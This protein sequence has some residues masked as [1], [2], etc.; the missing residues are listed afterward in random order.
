MKNGILLDFERMEARTLLATFMV[1]NNSP[2][3]ATSGSLAYEITQSN[4]TPATASTPNIIQ[5]DIAASGQQTI[6]LTQELP[7]VT[8]PL[9][10]QGYSEPGSSANTNPLTMADNAVL[11]VIVTGG[12]S[13]EN[14]LIFDIAAAG[15]SVEG[16]DLEGFTNN[17]ITINANAVA[18]SGT[19]IGVAPNGVPTA[20]TTNTVGVYVAGAGGGTIGGTAAANRN[21]ITGETYEAV[22]YM[23]AGVVYPS[24]NTIEGNFIGTDSDGTTIPSNTAVRNGNGVIEYAGIGNT[25][26]GSATG[27]G[28]V[29]SGNMIYGVGIATS[30]GVVLAGDVIQSNG[31]LGVLLISTSGTSITASTIG[32]T[33]A[34]Q[35]N[36]GQGIFLVGSTGATIGGTLAGAGDLIAGNTGDGIDFDATATGGLVTGSTISGNSGAGLS[37]VGTSV[38]LLS[39]EVVSSD[40]IQTNQVDGLDISFAPGTVVT[41]STIGGTASGQGNGG[42]GIRL[43][44]SSNVTIGGTALGVLVAGNLGDGIDFDTSSPNGQVLGTT[45]TGNAGVGVAF[46]GDTATNLTGSLLKLD[47]ITSNARGGVIAD[48]ASGTTLMSST[49]GG[50]EGLGNGAFGVSLTGSAGVT[51]A[52]STVIGNSGD[53]VDV[54]GSPGLD[55]TGGVVQLNTG[56]GILLTGS[57]DATISGS[58][59]GGTLFGSRSGYIVFVGGNGGDGIHFTEGST[60]GHVLG[61]QMSDNGGIGLSFD[62]GAGGSLSGEVANDDSLYGN[63]LG[64]VLINGAPGTVL[65]RDQVGGSNPLANLSF[66]VSLMGSADVSIMGLSATGNLGPGI[67][68]TQGS[69]GSTVSGSDISGNVGPGILVD[70][71]PGVVMTGNIV[72]YNTDDGVLIDGDSNDASLT[73]SMIYANH[74]HG[75]LVSVSGSVTISGDT[76]G[77]V[78]GANTAGG[79][80]ISFSGTNDEVIASTITGNGGIGLSVVS[81]SNPIITSDTIAMN[82]G[83]G[84]LLSSA[85]GATLD[86]STAGGLTSIFSNAGYG[87]SLIGSANVTVGGAAPDEGVVVDD[88]AGVGIAIDS[89][90]GVSVLNSKIT[91]NE[92]NGLAIRSLGTSLAGDQIMSNTGTGISLSNGAT[93]SLAGDN[94]SSNLGGGI[95]LTQGAV[96]TVGGTTVLAD[97][98]FGISAVGSGLDLAN[99]TVIGNSGIGVSITNPDSV[100][101]ITGTTIQSNLGG[102]VLI[103]GSP[104]GGLIASSTI[105]GTTSALGNNLFGLSL[106]NS[107]NV[108]LGGTL[109]NGILVQHNGGV[110]ISLTSSDGVLFNGSNVVADNAGDGV[111]V[112][113]SSHVVI[114]GAKILTNTGSGIKLANE[115]NASGVF[116]SMIVGNLG[117]GIV[118]NGSS[119]DSLGGSNASGLTISGNQGAGIEISGAFSPSI[120]GDTIQANRAGGI[121]LDGVANGSAEN[122]TIGG[123]TSILGNGLVGVSVTNVFVFGLSNLMVL[124]NA[125]DGILVA[126]G[127]NSIAIDGSQ[128]SGNAGAGLVASDSLAIQIGKPGKAVQVT[129]NLADGI[130]LNNSPGAVI[131]EAEVGVNGSV[132]IHVAASPET[133]IGSTAAGVIIEFNGSNGIV[134]NASPASTVVDTY[135]VMNKAVGSASSTQPMSPSARL[136]PALTT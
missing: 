5:F 75:V 136:S 54:S 109:G 71:S 34:G 111:A 51:L 15:G 128:V 4:A 89:S 21:V 18:V 87:V 119:G 35:G 50:A 48:F 28:N 83:G 55:L 86:S 27:S 26:G 76:I 132:G 8:Q 105:G 45:I 115:S 41:S 10:I 16:L 117:D 56:D 72:Q 68:T 92:G 12:E 110:G 33:A 102:G 98:P 36:A 79:I 116:A 135:V 134:L 37:F 100:P 88:N 82:T 120:V 59:I 52:G 44:N 13:I 95:L 24:N 60:G 103:S 46:N 11:T 97:G 73:S 126:S 130:D 38:S 6:T 74:G 14:G 1:T 20:A 49:I 66:G 112:V 61:S 123:V 39:G 129:G 131:V 108:D 77:G 29:I 47:L 85:S 67:A 64:G 78:F 19:F 133:T 43:E 121:R 65:D 96:A 25:I 69:N 90:T 70:G 62:R 84:V 80:L 53:G 91:A 63:L 23:P 107:A 32:G 122:C 93:A 99:S 22:E 94:V 31:S 118:V 106:V 127:S 125:G 3:A 124:S 9:D 101:S 17:A 58:T 40:T 57:T 104:V 42:V 81:S 114:Q 30:T 2:A 7:D 113:S